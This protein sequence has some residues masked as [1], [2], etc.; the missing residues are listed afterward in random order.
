MLTEPGS[1][2]SV[3]FQDVCDELLAG[4]LLT[5]Q[6][7]ARVFPTFDRLL[8]ATLLDRPHAAMSTNYPDVLLR[9]IIDILIEIR[10]GQDRL[11]EILKTCAPSGTYER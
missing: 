3:A 5:F 11:A 4:D 1:P 9:E 10:D 2:S 6:K 7:I 8:A